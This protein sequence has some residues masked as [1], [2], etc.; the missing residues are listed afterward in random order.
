MRILIDLDGVIWRGDQEIDGATHAIEKLKSYGHFYL[1]FTNN[2]YPTI[3]EL[4]EK[5]K[6]FG[7]DATEDIVLSSACVTAHLLKETGVKTAYVIGGPGIK[8]M[9]K[10]QKI[11]LTEKQPE[12]VVVGVDFK[13]TYLKLAVA[14]QAISE[15]AQFYATNSD[16][17]YPGSH[18]RLLPGAGAIVSAVS[19]CTQKDPIVAGKPNYPTVE[20][21]RQYGP[22]DLVIGDRFSTD[23]E[24][25]KRLG[26]TF[27]LVLT[28]VTKPN[29]K[30][31]STLRAT[32]YKAE[33]LKDL[34][35]I[36]IK[37]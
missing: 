33:S 14:L 11:K 29:E 10:N 2:S 35:D 15:G 20:F 27:G 19:Y 37:N 21:L 5:L 17:T 3:K 25:A 34:V 8:G 6:Q 12:A 32:D 23:F 4:T 1:F 16:S 26:A 7:I 31:I 36:V 30:D 22:F 13:L 18:Q 9:L 28:G 24:L